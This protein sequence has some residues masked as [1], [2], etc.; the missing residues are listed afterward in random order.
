MGES[1]RR[2]K[3][4]YSRNMLEPNRKHAKEGSSNY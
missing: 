2:V 1:G 3:Q 4:N